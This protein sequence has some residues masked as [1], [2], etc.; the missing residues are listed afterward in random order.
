MKRK[1]L[2]VGLI[3]LFV[4]NYIMPSTG[5]LIILR[6]RK[7]KYHSLSEGSGSPPG[8]EWN[9]TYRPP[10]MLYTSGYCVQETPDDGYIVTGYAAGYL[11]SNFYL[12]KVDYQGNE[13][14]NRT[15]GREG[16]DA[17]YS[18]G[19]WVE[20]TT[21]T[22]FII[23]G[24]T[25]FEDID[26]WLIKTDAGGNEEWNRTFG[27][28]GEQYGRCVKQTIDGGYIIT[29]VEDTH[30]WLIKTDTSGAEEWNK[31]YYSGYGKSL[32]I[33]QDGGYIVTGDLVNN[34]IILFKT[35]AN[36]SLE[37][38]NEFGSYSHQNTGNSVQQA[39]TGGYVVG[40]STGSYDAES[41]D[42]WLIKTDENGVEEWNRTFGGTQN[43]FGNSVIQTADGGYLLGGMKSWPYQFWII[44]TNMNGDVLWE[45]VYIPLQTASCLCV[46]QTKDQG[47]I[48]IGEIN[49]LSAPECVLVKIKPDIGNHP[50]DQPDTPT[51]QINGKINTPYTYSTTTDDCDG[52]QVWY[53]WDWGDGSQSIWF[54]PF[55]SGDKTNAQHTWST[56]G[57][58]AIKVKAKDIY[59]IESNWSDSLSVTMPLSYNCSVV[60]SFIFGLSGSL[61]CFHSYDVSWSR[62]KSHFLF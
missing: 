51:G 11:Y 24:Q 29:G 2:A 61:M 3:V 48:A 9:K 33:T 49:P 36:G 25:G 50:P 59:G 52:D 26:V 28:T 13:L 23:T 47:Y 8:E 34:K 7:N 39:S 31:T 14:W 45:Y 19:F 42:V 22:G 40:G 54:G 58:Y 37:W 18:I 32:A 21:D 55:H 16:I 56:T 20:I 41:L 46:Q 27:G 43:D 10:S 57:D 5:D 4:G 60:R 15:F 6:S 44:R 35:D 12:L 38:E 1:W 30:I 53:Q 17:G 62:K